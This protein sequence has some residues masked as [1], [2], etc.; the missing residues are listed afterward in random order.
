MSGLTAVSVN[1][2]KRVHMLFQSWGGFTGDGVFLYNALKKLS[3]DIVLYNAGQVASA[4]V[5]AF[6]GAHER[7]TTAN[8]VFMIHK[9]ISSATGGAGVERL[10]AAAANLTVDDDRI[11]GILRT[12]LRLPEELWVQF[13]LP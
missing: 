12:H 3:I 2:V 4:A 1:G 11:E 6:L 10:K 8:A 7:T 13:K 9:G 5:L